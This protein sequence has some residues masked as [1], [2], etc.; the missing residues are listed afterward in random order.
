MAFVHLHVHSEYS[1][2]DGMIR[3]KDAFNV[4]RE[5]GQAALAI[6]DH[7]NLAA[8]WTAQQSADAA[9]VKFIAGY[10]AYLAIGSRLEKH[11]IW[12]PAD[13]NSTDE[14]SERSEDKADTQ[15][16]DGLKSKPYMHLTILARNAQGWRNLVQLNNKAQESVW[17]KPRIDFELLAE[18]GE[19][20]IVL[21]GCLGGP[22]LGPMT[23]RAHWK[24]AV[25]T[26]PTDYA[27]T[28]AATVVRNLKDLI[29][30]D[31]FGVE[32]AR[33]QLASDGVPDPSN[34]EVS[35]LATLISQ[36]READLANYESES[37]SHALEEQLLEER[38]AEL[39][40]M[41]EAEYAAARENLRAI[42]T[43][44]GAEN[45]YVEVMEHG[46]DNESAVLPDVAELAREFGVGIVATND[47]HHTHESDAEAHAGWLLVQSKSTVDNPK[48][49]FHG[50]GYWLRSEQEMRALRPEAW[51]QEACDTTQLIADRCED[52]VLPTPRNLM[53][54]FQTPEGYSSNRDY[55]F[56]LL[57]DGAARL[58]GGIDAALRD[59]VMAEMNVIETAGMADYFLVVHDLISWARSTRPSRPGGPEKKPI[60]V[61]PGRGSA[62]GSMVAYLLGITQINPVRYGLLFER[63][64]ELGRSEPPD[65]DIDFP[66]GRRQEV[67]QYL[68]DRWGSENVASIGTFRIER[69]KQAINDAA[70]VIGASKSGAAMNT[71]VPNVAAKPMPMGHLL[72]ADIP[73]TAE[74]RRLYDKDDVVR[75]VH[76]IAATF[77]DVVS[78]FGI[79]ASGIIVSAE[80]L[81][82]LVPMRKDKGI[83]VLQ[84]S[85]PEAEQF[86][87]L[88]VDVLGLRN[89]D[90]IDRAVEYIKDTTG[91]YVDPLRIP[92]PDQPAVGVEASRVAA[93]WKLIADGHTAGVFQMESP[94]MTELAMQVAPKR[95]EEESAIVALYRPGPMGMGAHSAYANRKRGIEHADY[96]VFT[97]DPRE[98]RELAKVLD[99]TFGLIVYQEQVMALG[100]LMAGFDAVGRSKLRKAVSKKKKQDLEAI[101]PIFFD[102]A[103]REL[104]DQDG[105]VTSIAFSPVTVQAVWD[106]LLV[107]AEYAFNKA[108]S[109]TYGY[110]A[111]MTA[112]YK[113]NWP[114]AY[115]A[116]NLSVTDKPEKRL[117]VL[118]T[119]RDEGI[120]VLPPDVNS[121]SALTVP[122]G[123]AAITFGISEVKDLGSVGELIA[124][125][126]RASGEF[127]SLRDVY[128]RVQKPD[129]SGSAVTASHLKALIASGAADKFGPRL[130]HMSI[131]GAIP[132]KEI[133]VPAIEWGV[134]ERSARQREALLTPLGEHP[135]VA[136]RDQV[137][138]VRIPSLTGRR[139]LELV[140]VPVA[141][142]PDANGT[143]VSTLGVLAA[144]SERQYSKGRLANIV[145]E[146]SNATITGT[147][148]DSALTE[149]REGGEVPRPGDIVIVKAKVRFNVIAADPEDPGS[150]DMSVKELSVSSIRAVQIADPPFGG[151]PATTLPRID[152]TASGVTTSG[153]AVVQPSEAAPFEEE[154]EAPAMPQSDMTELLSD[155]LDWDVP[156]VLDPS[157]DVASAAAPPAPPTTTAAAAPMSTG[158]SGSDDLV[159]SQVTTTLIS[160]PPP[161][162]PV[163][164]AA[165]APGTREL[166]IAGLLVDADLAHGGVGL[167]THVAPAHPA[168]F[169]MDAPPLP[170][171]PRSAATA[172]TRSGEWDVQL[173][174]GPVDGFPTYSGWLIG[175]AL[176]EAGESFPGV[177]SDLRLGDRIEATIATD[178]SNADIVHVLVN[179][180]AGDGFVLA[181]G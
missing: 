174:P 119:L 149:I 36:K 106:T 157:Y 45:T 17:H 134:L 162:P 1:P 107:F 31:P 164:H 93:G 16:V 59:R 34:D 80:P 88:K 23:R 79:H 165:A 163:V 54:R 156:M 28:E 77:E 123:P 127:V 131:V 109:A 60:L 67:I 135:L 154:P 64:Y 3:V 178:T 49:Q 71:L 82:D 21:T 72:D 87:L 171:H 92:D 33:A 101:Q 39:A 73:A 32:A 13:D 170:T 78:G 6:T 104:C 141:R 40:R 25:D 110:L 102:Q 30:A 100:T 81:G 159:T 146:G 147:I 44:V 126:R 175:M 128:T 153:A 41:A 37:G 70:R 4:A 19:G 142:I 173:V 108:H 139:E 94:K 122:A 75:R 168:I 181:V 179:R 118:S 99:E 53:P 29:E 43:A 8:A 90:I 7:G 65:I 96:S 62:G 158:G 35:E 115:A 74:Y 140:P 155:P 95:L 143:M 151:Y 86:G 113:A 144:W 133:P 12:V 50:R 56:H 58:F 137:S 5:V 111:F 130:G 42:I 48:Y 150:E 83:W 9:G 38:K 120:T 18:H 46:I 27:T 136:L 138:Q 85:G 68:R 166:E 84:W 148:W 2:L 121:T 76:G 129:G 61:G 24:A 116:A 125:E 22:V 105:T 98:E 114:A 152:L 11:S 57:R 51:W 47:A 52:R 97:S 89:L 103:T 26:I 66:Q 55:L 160:P 20:L 117:Q 172:P 176:I 145:L 91:E 167:V 132:A 112:F 69:T 15:Q 177:G 63:F 169:E 161:P 10:E 180:E 14:D 124:A